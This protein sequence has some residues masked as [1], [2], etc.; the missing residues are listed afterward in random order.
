MQNCRGYLL[1]LSVETPLCTCLGRTL[2]FTHVCESFA[3]GHEPTRR[4][5]KFWCMFSGNSGF[6][7][8]SSDLVSLWL[9]WPITS[10]V[11]SLTFC[12]RVWMRLKPASGICVCQ[13]RSFMCKHILNC[14]SLCWYIDARTLNSD[15]SVTCQ[16]LLQRSLVHDGARW[17]QRY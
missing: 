2:P 7:S 13:T 3:C 11:V 6:F 1:S 4:A 17:R 5:D 14:Q 8:W 10:H 16:S 9:L 15:W 12:F